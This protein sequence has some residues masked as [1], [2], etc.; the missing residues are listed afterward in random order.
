MG[1][2]KLGERPL[3]KQRTSD[4]VRAAG[5]ADAADEP[6]QGS[7]NFEVQQSV[8]YCGNYAADTV[9]YWRSRGAIL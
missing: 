6:R 5:A 8:V 7:K 3:A 9:R 2:A 1:S 4:A